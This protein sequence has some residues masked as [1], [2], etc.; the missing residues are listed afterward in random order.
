MYQVMEA[1]LLVRLHFL[2]EKKNQKKVV[3]KG[4]SL[5][6]HPE[7]SKSFSYISDELMIGEFPDKTDSPVFVPNPQLAVRLIELEPLFE[8][9]YTTPSQLV[10]EKN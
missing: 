8:S 9:G 7:R 4:F 6:F 2:Q 3:R 5:F 1:L 10:S